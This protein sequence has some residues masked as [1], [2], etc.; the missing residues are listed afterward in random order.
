[1][2]AETA[3]FTAETARSL[4]IMATGAFAVP[5]LSRPL[6]LPA[7]VGEILFGML[8]GPHLLG[9]VILTDFTSLLGQLGCFLL[10][11]MAGMELDFSL[12]EKVGRSKLGRMGLQVLAIFALS[13]LLA[14][15]LGMSW[16]IGMILSAI[17]IGLPLMLL[18]ETRH[19]RTL[20]G[21]KLLVVGSLGEFLCIVLATGI[22][23]W[24]RAGG[25]N[26]LFLDKIGKL[27][28]VFAL[29][30]AL[31]FIL[32]VA[33]WWKAE[34]FSRM[35]ETHDPSEI[36][37]RAGLA[38]MFMLVAATANFGIDPILGAFM[39]GALF[40]FVF[41]A[42]GPLELKF[43]SLAN[44]F[45]VPFFFITVGLDFHLGLAL[46]SDL[47]A[48][49]ELLVALLV[50]RFLPLYLFR[51]PDSS[52]RE[53]LAGALL[54]S[55]PLTLLVVL[56]N[57]GLRL[58]LIDKLANTTV[59]LLAVVASIVYPFLFKMLARGIP[60]LPAEERTRG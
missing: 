60:A 10:M 14:E 53:A 15:L 25:L 6:R 42:K 39:A 49:L 35:T 47:V 19:S 16:F 4:L 56:G 29:A 54:L 17:S 11:L 28:L 27:L 18:Q 40:S 34:A 20:F 50:A 36:G 41:R 7:A 13:F 2:E 1:V 43:L 26:Y 31:L 24:C 23:A 9:W 32:R 55:A 3:L 33:V 30:W 21:Q 52:P 44:G 48:F 51:G 38:L 59:I 22:A 57:M 46:Q 45:F 12:V 37:V 58:G 8:I 5:L